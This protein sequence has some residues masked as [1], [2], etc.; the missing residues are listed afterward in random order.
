[1]KGL[2]DAL[3]RR[4]AG[5]A[6]IFLRYMAGRH[7]AALSERTG[8]DQKRISRYEKGK[9]Q[10]LRPT[11]DRLAAGVGVSPERLDQLLALYRAICEES[12][13][14]PVAP[15]PGDEDS[16]EAGLGDL[17]ELAT[18]IAEELQPEIYQ[19]L[20]ELEAE[21]NVPPP[22]PTPQEARSEAQALW[23]RFEP[24]PDR[25]RRLVIEHGEE[26]Q[27]WAFC[28][29]LCEESLDAGARAP[30]DGQALADLALSVA[31]IAPG[32]DVLRQRLTAFALACAA[33][34]DRAAGETEEAEVKLGR[35]KALWTDGDGT[36]DLDIGGLTDFVSADA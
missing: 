7:Q 15:D 27:T 1:M 24:L 5:L 8:I 2:S 11:L 19:Y 33:C 12:E 30:E 28:E 13:S 20:V 32:S 16:M 18:E 23:R 17:T 21:L 31:E 10:P 22:P 36:D 4:A 29:R 26:Y 3:D 25:I 6:V 9:I 35:A 34:A 14:K